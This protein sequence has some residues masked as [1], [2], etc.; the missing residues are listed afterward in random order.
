MFGHGIKKILFEDVKR[1]SF[2]QQ[3]KLHDYART[4]II[5]RP[6][7][8]RGSDLLR[9]SGVFDKKSVKEMREAILDC[10]RVDNGEW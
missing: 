10:E 6:A 2:S 4:M 8:S 3:K 7:E 5:S 1:L 9:F